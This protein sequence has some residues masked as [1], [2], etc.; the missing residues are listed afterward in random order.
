MKKD[1][2]SGV[3]VLIAVAVALISVAS[4]LWSAGNEMRNSALAT[5]KQAAPTVRGAY[6][7]E[8]SDLP[9]VVP[10]YSAVTLTYRL[11]GEGEAPRIGTLLPQIAGVEM[12]MRQEAEDH[13]DFH[14]RLWHYTF[15]AA[16]N[17]T[18]PAV[19]IAGIDPEANRTY[20]LHTD[21]LPITVTPLPASEVLDRMN[22][23]PTDSGTIAWGRWGGYL[24]A[25]MIG[26][27]MPTL[28]RRIRKRNIKKIVSPFAKALQRTESPEALLR[29]LLATDADRFA[30]EADALQKMVQRGETL[31]WERIREDL[32][33]KEQDAA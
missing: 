14:R 17:I 5:P 3:H 9:A 26:F 29:L 2:G 4:L 23:L 18:I 1:R 21:A 33:E 24:L 10:A 19:T 6:R 12:R 22:S 11:E 13:G 15:L 25:F 16:G 27:F 31:D 30:T 8:R 28:W 32:I 20:R 7:L